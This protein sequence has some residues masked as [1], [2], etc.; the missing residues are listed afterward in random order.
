MKKAFTLAEVLI[1]L[2]IIGIVAAMTLPSVI[3]HYRKKEIA[4]RLKKF[5]S[6]F[7]NALHMAVAEYGDPSTWTFPSKQNDGEQITTFVN[8]YFFPYFTGLKQ[9]D[10]KDE[11]CREIRK[12][13]YGQYNNSTSVYIFNDGGCFGILTGGS[14]S[15]SAMIHINYD[16]NCLG[17]PNKYD[18]DIFAFAISYNSSGYFKF[19]AG[20][21]G[22]WAL[23]TREKLLDACKRHD[24]SPH[25]EGTCSALIEYDGWE[26]KDDYP[27]L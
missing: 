11:S 24:T 10:A 22:T 4:L 12:I 2:G 23:N 27:W 8:T 18:K 9:C 7:N 15:S 20:G 19:K 26:I 25:L 16:Y 21:A 1:T 3:G 13:L 14:S 6:T 17:K 5:S